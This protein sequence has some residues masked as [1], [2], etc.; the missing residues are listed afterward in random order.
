MRDEAR[1]AQS[2][3]IFQ[4]SSKLGATPFEILENFSTFR[5]ANDLTSIVF[6]CFKSQ[7]RPEWME[8]AHPL[9][10]LELALSLVDLVEYTKVETQPNFIRFRFETHARLPFA[11]TAIK[12]G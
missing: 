3:Y 1:S 5:M 4:V 12:V 8:Q 6:Y 2:K 10:A 9:R 7:L 11:E